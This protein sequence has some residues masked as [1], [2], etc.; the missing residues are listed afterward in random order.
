MTEPLLEVR[1]L[2]VTFH[3]RGLALKRGRAV[4]AV[5]GIS[6]DIARGETFGLVGES[7]SG[8]STT[9]RGILRLVDAEGEVRLEGDDV[10]GADRRR[11]RQLRPKMQMVF[12]DPYSSIDPSR[13]IVDIVGE[14]LRVHTDLG[15]RDREAR[16]ADL[17]EQVGLAA[18]HLQRY[19]HEFSGGQRQRIAIARA[20]AL[21]PSLAVCD[22]ATSALDVSTQNQVINLLEE[23]RTT[24]DVAYLFIT[25]NLAVVRHIADRIGV[26][27]LGRLVEVADADRIF[28]EPAHPYTRSLLAAMPIARPGGRHRPGEQVAGGELPDPSAPPSGCSFHPRCP[29]A[30]EVC[31]REDPASRPAPGGGQ[32]ACHLY[33]Q[34]VQLRRSTAHERA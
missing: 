32:V 12:Q 13:R 28:S 6:F 15:R 34:P 4:H 18:H 19:P 1:D 25:H 9:A 7:G 2:R 20:I 5:R 30:M 29:D 14:S 27:Y 33:E 3:P 16:V 8:K 22:E 31:A 26:M 23:L 17:L 21:N 24:H 10:L 11:L